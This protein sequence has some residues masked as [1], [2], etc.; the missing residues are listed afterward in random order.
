MTPCKTSS[1]PGGARQITPD[2]RD[3][4]KKDLEAFKAKDPARASMK[5]EVLAATFKATAEG[6]KYAFDSRPMITMASSVALIAKNLN[7]I[8]QP[9]RAP[10]YAY[11]SKR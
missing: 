11:K 8:P 3:A 1:L 7:K 2:K 9:L 10:L 4:Y 5:P 6:S